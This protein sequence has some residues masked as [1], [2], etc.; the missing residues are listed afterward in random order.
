MLLALFFLTYLPAR[1]FLFFFFNDPATTEIYP[2]SLHDALP[3][4]GRTADRTVAVAPAKAK[5]RADV[6][7]EL[8]RRRHHARLN[9]D[10]LRLA[11][12]LGQHAVNHR[13]HF[14]NIVNDH[15]VGAFI[16]DH[17][18]T[19]REE[20]LHGDDHVFGVSVAQET[21]DR[22]FLHGQR[23]GF[24]LGAPSIRFLLDRLYRA[25][26]QNVPFHSPPHT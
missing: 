9:L 19:H 20:F 11:V 2:L 5:L 8:S 15:G 3:I 10:F 7:G 25:N 18:P 16:R 1:S 24:H 22:Y 14:R 26:P 4:L 23:F 21:R 12:E 6:T 17:V 13:D